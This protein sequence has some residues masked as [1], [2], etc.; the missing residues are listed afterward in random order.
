MIH[1]LS[2]KNFRKILFLFFGIAF[3]FLSQPMMVVA[4]SELEIPFGT[5]TNVKNPLDY[6][7]Q[8]HKFSIGVASILAVIMM[9]IGGFLW[10]SAAGNSSLITKGKTLI[11]GAVVGLIILLF[12]YY[13]LAG[14]NPNLVNLRIQEPQPVPGTDNFGATVCCEYSS[15]KGD[16]YHLMTADNY[17]C[18][19]IYG[20]SNVDLSYCPGT[21]EA[22]EI[23][24][25]YNQLPESP[26]KYDACEKDYRCVLL[27][28]TGGGAVFSDGL[29][30]NAASIT[31]DNCHYLYKN[32]CQKDATTACFYS[33]EDLDEC[34]PICS[35][36]SD[37]T[38]CNAL[39]TYCEY[40]NSK[41][42]NK[43]EKLDTTWC[44]DP[45]FITYCKIDARPSMPDLCVSR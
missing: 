31:P 21:M 39:S 26:T 25:T 4:A 38:S 35:K 24:L 42:Q 12:S 5:I 32:D 9:M 16:V 15:I 1:Y 8:I 41:C 2:P 28:A 20:G 11:S 30:V 33:T 45:Q 10:I 3:L 40:K 7:V 18:A 13:I 6:I 23:C 36:I 27:G 37:Q 17:T 14:I 44:K 22:S 29:C 34:T 19:A 43:C